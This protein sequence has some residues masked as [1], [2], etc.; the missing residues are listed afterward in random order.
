MNAGGKISGLKN[1]ASTFW[2]ERNQRE[3]NM[4]VAALMVIVFGLFYLLL[5]D[6]A[7]SGRNDLEKR[8]PV[9]R[10]QA[11]EVQA[12]AKEAS[13]LA[14][15][16]SAAP[17]VVLTQESL[18]ASLTRKGLKP[19]SVVLTGDNAKVQL[20][21]VSF[22]GTIDWL[23][24]LRRTARVSVVDANIEAQTQPDMVNA[25]LTLRQQKSE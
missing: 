1:T 11:A 15:R 21:A 24:E 22:A 8:L 6:P 10:Q 25:T 4:L 9:L 12:M 19:Q 16:A 7:V 14:G 5:I 17:S 18:Q 20:S 23:D 13:S 3:R 2:G